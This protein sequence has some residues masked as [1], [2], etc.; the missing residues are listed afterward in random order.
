MK[1]STLILLLD[2]AHRI[3]YARG[4]AGRF[5]TLNDAL[6]FASREAPKDWRGQDIGELLA[7]FAHRKP[8]DDSVIE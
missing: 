2:A 6:A 7:N 5:H 4:K 8:D 1:L 3:G